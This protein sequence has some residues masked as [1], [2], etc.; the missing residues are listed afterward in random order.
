[1][2]L[3]DRSWCPDLDDLDPWLEVD[4]GSPHRLLSIITQ[5]RWNP[6]QQWVT[7]YR[8]S[9]KPNNDSAFVSIP[10]VYSGNTAEPE[11]VVNLFPVDTVA[12]VLRLSPVTF[13]DVACIRWDI[14]GCY[15]GKYLLAAPRKILCLETCLV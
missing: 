8:L 3:S 1:M 2:F 9:Y 12:Q 6:S 5:G 7:S 4:F 11:K 14:V 10:E 15:I 13:N